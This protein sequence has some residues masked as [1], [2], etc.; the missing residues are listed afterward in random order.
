MNVFLELRDGARFEQFCKALLREEF[1]RFIAFSAPDAGVDGYDEESGT[2]FQSY[3]PEGK[4]RKDKIVKDIGKVLN[5]GPPPKRWILVIPKDPTPAQKS[6]VEHE[7][8]ESSVKTAIWGETELGSLLR[9]HPA[10]RSE[11]FPT[12]ISKVMRR[13]AKGEKPRSGDAEAGQEISADEGEEI[14]QSIMKLA[15]ATALRRRRKPISADYSREQVEFRNHF[16]VSK[17]TRLKK[18]EMGNA[19]LYLDQKIYARRAGE[20]IAQQRARLIGGIHAIKKA[21]G[22]S[23]QRYREELRRL[24][25]MPS[26]TAMDMKQLKKVFDEFRRRQGLADARTL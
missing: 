22:L 16:N 2:A 18:E 3:F 4:P 24:T 8:R 19:R 11:F 6:W 10:V 5:P 12:E 20:P 1:P 14:Q 21:L 25:G 17:Y 9:K 23:E 13:L 15:E 26:L 7:F